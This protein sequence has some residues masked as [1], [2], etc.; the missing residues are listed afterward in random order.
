M[1]KQALVL[2][3][4][5][6]IYS[7]VFSWL[8]VWLNLRMDLTIP[9]TV[10][11]LVLLA[12]SYL[13]AFFLAPRVQGTDEPAPSL[14]VLLLFSA[15]YFLFM[16][17][18]TGL[19]VSLGVSK[20]GMFLR[21]LSRW[22]FLLSA[23][24][25]VR[26]LTHRLMLFVGVTAIVAQFNVGMLFGL[27]ALRIAPWILVLVSA[28]I[29]LWISRSLS[30][31]EESPADRITKPLYLW[32]F[33]AAGV[34]ALLG[35]LNTYM[36]GS[37]AALLAWVAFLVL[38]V[39]LVDAIEPDDPD[40]KASALGADFGRLFLTF[41]A[42]FTLVGTVFHFSGVLEALLPYSIGF[43]TRFWVSALAIAAVTVG[44]M[45]FL[46]LGRR[47]RPEGPGRKMLFWGVILFFIGVFAGGSIFG[48]MSK[49]GQM[50]DFLAAVVVLGLLVAP[51]MALAQILMG[52]GL[53]RILFTLD[54]PPRG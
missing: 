54:P 4:T 35:I 41:V 26:F 10:Q 50:F 43:K 47:M 13:S 15:G 3:L 7:V 16:Q 28:V 9:F 14:V 34:L 45:M 29:V 36:L 1:K 2:G 19:N 25:T 17:L 38:F 40:H 31:G 12:L 23:L 5:A 39:L 42:L 51:I 8:G 30:F 33:G 53:L 48:S 46:Q 37:T 6:V 49:N 32:L 44:I 18:L 20:L 52:V 11:T 27:L 24:L 21:D 22:C